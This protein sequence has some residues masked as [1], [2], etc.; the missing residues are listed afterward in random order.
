M[1]PSLKRRA[2]ACLV[3]GV[4]A[5]AVT[6][7]ARTASASPSP[8]AVPDSAPRWTGDARVLGNTSADQRVDFG[9]LLKMRDQ[10]GAVA[11]LQNISDPNSPD[12][13]KWLT[14]G[15]F[16]ANYGPA[17][18]D[19]AAVRNWL[20]AQG[21]TLRKTLPSGLYVEVS[22]TV[23]QVQ[24]VFKTT[25]KNY[26]YRGQTVHSNSSAL[27]FP[28]ST[29]ASVINAVGGILGVDQGAQIHTTADTLPGPPPGNRY[30]VQPCSDYY[31]QKIA[32][33]KPKAYGKHQPYAVCGYVPQQYQ[34]AYGESGLIA[35]G[36]DGRGV[37]VAITD[38]FAAPTIYQDAQKYNQVHHQPAFKPGQFSQITPP[39]DGYSNIEDCGG[40]GWYGEETLDVEAVHAMAP[41]AKVVY[42][43]GS[44]C[45]AGLD[46][47]WAETIDNHVADVITNSWGNGTDNI[48]DLGPDVIAFYNQFSLEAALTGITVNFSSGDSG[49]ETSGGTDLASKTVDFP[50]DLPYVTGIG[51]TSVGIGKRGNWLWEAGWQTAYAPLTN[52]A[53]T[54]TPPGTYA[55]G[56]GG[57]TS[58]IYDQPFYQK[59][60][61][62]SSIS[63][64]FGSTPM[65][66]VPD[67]SMPGDANTGFLVGETQEFSDG[68]YWD[69][70]RIGG[71]SLSS[72]LM[73]GV[74]AV[75]DQ[76]A[77]KSLG[78]VNPL[79]YQLL[80][81]PAV[82][83]IVAPT[84]PIAQVRT[85]YTNGVDGA[86]DYKLQTVDV[87][88]STIRSTK[89]YDAE[90][91]VGSPAGL[92]FFVRL[93]A[94]AHRR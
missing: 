60:K 66:T 30:G 49:D 55:S 7:I 58:V 44:D 89:G 39:A 4:T 63:K 23:A 16:T 40:N 76:L 91:G 33:D 92:P 38:A 3:A 6:S 35:A 86:I 29:P 18:P 2:M 42:V 61:V 51:G 75:A 82:H 53:W 48:D 13:G 54:P 26:S 46:E 84:S 69:Q 14:S 85:E 67:I 21:F 94:A 22:G 65:R 73:A 74:I 20:G 10:A 59:G 57:G 28:S 19:V 15:G 24:K 25:V 34:A 41:G 11:T 88:S 52:G 8:R 36:I 93:V 37:T 27:S 12:Y 68:T 83:D 78:F 43:G 45:L 77:H 62:P 70:Y 80:Q 17:K 72:P 64:Y 81:T 50:A 9:V 5:V 79:Y 1:P 32:T 56:G 71:T 87:Q 47:A 31:G 90:T